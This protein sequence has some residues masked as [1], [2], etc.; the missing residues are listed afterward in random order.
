MR[1]SLTFT[2]AAGTVLLLGAC[3][4]STPVATNASLKPGAPPPSSSCSP[5]DLV[6]AAA[7]L[8]GRP[9][10]LV[11]LASQIT[12]QN[13]GTAAGT[14]LVFNVF[15]EVAQLADAGH[16]A[17]SWTEQNSLD[18]AKVTTLG[19]ACGNIALTG[20]ATAEA[21][22]AALR[23]SG[24]YEVRGGSADPSSEAIAH[25]AKGGVQ[26]P[27]AG[28]GTWLSG[29]GLF[30]GY[31]I[32]TF[33]VEVFGG[34]A[35][36]ISVARPVT[37]PA[38]QPSALLGDGVVA[39]CPNVN[40]QGFDN[41]QL[42]VQKTSH[43]LPVAS[44]EFLTCVQASEPT[45][46]SAASGL[47]LA[48]AAASGGVGGTV[49]NFSPHEVVF[50]GSV[51]LTFVHEPTN[52][53]ANEP[54]RGQGG[55]IVTVKAT[56]QNGTPWEGVRVQLSALKNEGSFVAVCHDQADTDADGLA[57]FATASV[58]K[59]GGYRLVAHTVPSA[60][61]PDVQAFAADSVSSGLFNVK[62]GKTPDSCS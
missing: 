34:Y 16:A 47:S 40:P 57:T 12:S 6:K 58:N 56:A 28:F 48:L 43:V 60:S 61:D 14:A 17:G 3:D 19:L 21:F 29:R 26:P 5:N 24:L 45:L 23:S 10:A 51:N 37:P 30:Y 55:S 35:M 31:P 53:A 13:A 7:D 49:R 22:S 4:A 11:D 52:G 9:S 54:L 59:A 20:A 62:N 50:P 46:R 8:A 33:G 1:R 2:L 39:L 25:D 18:G 38:T 42:R 36:D 15:A 44:G 27:A 41:A 32:V